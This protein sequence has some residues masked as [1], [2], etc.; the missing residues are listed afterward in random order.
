MRWAGHETR[1]GERRGAY[2]LWWGN[3]RE[4]DHLED[5]GVDRSIILKWMCKKWGGCM[6]WID[7]AQD[8]DQWGWKLL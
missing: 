6:D 2:R 3:M 5:L 4:R 8:R 1:V 7:L